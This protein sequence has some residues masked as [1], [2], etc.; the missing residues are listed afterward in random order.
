MCTRFIVRFVGPCMSLAPGVTVPEGCDK[1]CH[2]GGGSAPL[3]G[4]LSGELGWVNDG[5]DHVSLIGVA[6]ALPP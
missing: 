3:G 2:E 1:L 6:T 4:K 5:G